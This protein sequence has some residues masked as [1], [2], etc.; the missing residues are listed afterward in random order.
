MKNL[1]YLAVSY[2]KYNRIRT[3]I[4]ILTLISL[5]YLPMALNVITELSEESL[6]SRAEDSPVVIGARGSDLDLVMN[7]LYFQQ[8]SQRDIPYK[9]VEQI[10]R[11][12]L[13]TPVPYYLG[14]TARNI[15]VVGTTPAYFSSRGLQMEEGHMITG[16]GD[17]VLGRNTA[18]IL[19]LKPGDTLITDPEN[20][21]HLAGGYPLELR[22]TGILASSSSW[23]DKAVFTDIKTAWI[24][25]GLGHG[26][27]DLASNPAVILKTEESNI[28]GNASVKMYNSIDPETRSSFHFH[29]ALDD[30]PLSGILYFPMDEKSE[31]L[32][33]S[34]LAED[35]L[36]QAVESDKVILKL[37]D[38][39]FRIR[40]I[41]NWVL[42]LTLSITTAAVLFIIALTIRLRKNESETLYKMG[43]SKS[44][45]LKL[46]AVEIT[47]LSFFSLFLSFI[48]LIV[49]WMFRLQI[50]ELLIQ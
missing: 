31:A 29:G 50:L 45:I 39:L 38:T 25:R 44:L 28:V 9:T 17:C 5:F 30:F 42:V 12:S 37:L 26:H 32:I 3:L 4:L 40:T 33:L 20:P 11:M 18:D 47:I 27:D 46:S 24:A 1:L 41:L 35:N 2:L 23:D 15:P 49:T 19:G 48:L 10:N 34:A 43:G 16:I 36:L 13:G 22:V 21:Y 14:D 7:A 6:N 8:T